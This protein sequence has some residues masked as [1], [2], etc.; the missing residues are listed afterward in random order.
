MPTAIIRNYTGEA[1]VVAADGMAEGTTPTLS[2]RK[3]FK[4][5]DNKS[6]AYAFAGRVAIGPDEGP[7]TWFDFRDRI[8]QAVQSLSLDLYTTLSD[9]ATHLADHAHRALVERCASHH[10]TFDNAAELGAPL[11]CVFISGYFKQLASSVIIEFCR[12]NRQF[13][14][15]KVS[16]DEPI[17]RPL[18]RHGSNVIDAYLHQNHPPF[19][20]ERYLRPLEVPLPHFSEAMKGAVLRSRQY[21][22]VCS[23]PEAR[24][25][26]DFCKTIGGKIHMVSIT[27]T[28]GIQWIPGFE[29]EE[30]L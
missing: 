23:S 3:I 26:D 14:T 19:C 16:V 24:A 8:N 4:F 28:D 21:I 29:H 9:Y 25:M 12:E 15:P 30:N 17:V 22:E 11:A 20:S 6:L 18:R 13:A 7:E 5:G 27:P 10:L 1:F 2:R